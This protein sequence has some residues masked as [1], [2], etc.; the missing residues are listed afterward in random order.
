MQNCIYC[1]IILVSI[2]L[3]SSCSFL[4]DNGLTPIEKERLELEESV[5]SYKVLFWKYMKMITMNYLY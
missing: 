3:L 1:S 2:S 4:E 5:Y